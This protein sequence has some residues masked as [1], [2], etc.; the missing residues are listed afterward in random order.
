[1]GKGSG[2]RQSWESRFGYLR[3]CVARLFL[4][5]L[6]LAIPRVQV[7]HVEPHGGVKGTVS[8]VQGGAI[9]KAHVIIHWDAVSLVAGSKDN[10][11]GSD[12][13]VVESDESGGYSKDLAPGYYDVFMTSNGFSPACKKLRIKSQEYVVYDVKLSLDRAVLNQVDD[14][15]P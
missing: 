3:T 6:V 14:K 1:M 9:P 4:G 2:H 15:I 7:A 11:S 13:V 10:L 8:D 5:A 12:D